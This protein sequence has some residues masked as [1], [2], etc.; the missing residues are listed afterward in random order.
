MRIW[1]GRAYGIVL[2]H[3]SLSIV[4]LEN[5]GTKEEAGGAI[6]RRTSSRHAL[7]L[8]HLP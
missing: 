2:C 3:N 1:M 8:I 5:V 4:Q 6:R 7:P